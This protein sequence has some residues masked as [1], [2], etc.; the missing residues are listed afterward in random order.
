MCVRV[1]ACVLPEIVAWPSGSAC[2]CVESSCV[3]SL[4][5]IERK[6]RIKKRTKKKSPKTE[7]TSGSSV[8]SVKPQTLIFAHS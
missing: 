6:K 8:A 1:R 5:E 3:F 7:K 4:E 2:V